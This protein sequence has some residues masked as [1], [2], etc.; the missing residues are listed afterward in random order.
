[1]WDAERRQVIE[2]ERDDRMRVM[3]EE[4]R[5]MWGLEMHRGSG[6]ADPSGGPVARKHCVTSCQATTTN[7]RYCC[8]RSSW[9]WANGGGG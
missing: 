4:M 3:L 7:L 2:E 8:S 5:G 6:L 1:M 9:E